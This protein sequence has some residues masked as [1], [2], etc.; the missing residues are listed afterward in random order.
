MVY[1]QFFKW[2]SN[3][4]TCLDNNVLWNNTYISINAGRINLIGQVPSNLEIGPLSILTSLALK[5]FVQKTSNVKF[6]CMNNNDCY[7][8]GVY[9]SVSY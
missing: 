8:N 2:D 6:R 3:F 7:N 9:C 1:C 5:S 4:L